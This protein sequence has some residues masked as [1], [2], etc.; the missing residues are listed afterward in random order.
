MIFLI[1]SFANK[2][3]NCFTISQFNLFK[4][5]FFV[6]PSDLAKTVI[7]ID[8]LRLVFIFSR[9]FKSSQVEFISI[10]NNFF[11][12]LVSQAE[13]AVLLLATYIELSLCISLISQ[14]KTPKIT[15]SIKTFKTDHFVKWFSVKLFLWWELDRVISNTSTFTSFD[16]LFSDPDICS[17]FIFSCFAKWRFIYLIINLKSLLSL[18]RNSIL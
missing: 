11:N 4:L 15:L 1:Q 8:G 6:A 14:F 13:S 10:D 12:L 17:F 16:K 3:N 18:L 9:E 7:W 2:A 5:E